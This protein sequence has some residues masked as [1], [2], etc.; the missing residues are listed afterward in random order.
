MASFVETYDPTI[1]DC[2]RKQW[3]VDDQP[4][5]LEVLDTAGQ[6]KFSIYRDLDR[7]IYDGKDRSCGG[8]A[9]VASNQRNTLRCEINGFGECIAQHP[10]TC[11]LNKLTL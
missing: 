6:G 1:E 11:Y 9:I 2:Y 7:N 8:P 5:L 10:R 3:S 4:C